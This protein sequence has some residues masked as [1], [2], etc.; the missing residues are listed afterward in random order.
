[1]NHQKGC[2]HEFKKENDWGSGDYSQRCVKC[3][4]VE[5]FVHEYP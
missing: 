3:G 4:F 2:T 1:M 5:M